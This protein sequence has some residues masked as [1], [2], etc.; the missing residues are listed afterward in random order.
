MLWGRA[1]R[2]RRGDFM[3]RHP[4]EMHTLVTRSGCEPAGE[5]C[6][7]CGEEFSLEEGDMF[8]TLMP[9]LLSVHS[10]R[11]SSTLRKRKQAGLL[12]HPG[13]L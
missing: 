2:S 6:A 11:A 12:C 7:G 9:L 4:F 8:Q 13:A 5:D 10:P 1:G 3:G